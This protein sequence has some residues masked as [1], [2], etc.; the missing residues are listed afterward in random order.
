MP[1]EFNL[2]IKIIIITVRAVGPAIDV[3]RRHNGPSARTGQESGLFIRLWFPHGCVRRN[4]VAISDI[5]T[6][7]FIRVVYGISCT[8]GFTP[9]M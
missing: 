5:R 3:I 7:S 6:I 4:F 2:Q 8:R 9:K 1:G